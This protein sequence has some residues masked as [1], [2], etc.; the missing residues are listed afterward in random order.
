MSVG[1][2]S[3]GVL[4]AA[5]RSPHLPDAAAI[6]DEFHVAGF[7]T[8]TGADNALVVSDA[9]H[10]LDH[11]GRCARHLHGRFGACLPPARAPDTVRDGL[12][13]LQRGR[14]E[15][16]ARQVFYGQLAAAGSRLTASSPSGSRWR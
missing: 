8:A 1:Y 2:I 11:S 3:S 7:V 15:A 10:V 13:G 16:R 9:D 12:R 4:I 14:L 5:R 6:I